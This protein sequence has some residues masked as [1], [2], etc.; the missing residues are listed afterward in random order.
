M[1]D[2]SD[3]LRQI[4]VV[5]GDTVLSCEHHDESKDPVEVKKEADHLEVLRAHL[6]ERPVMGGRGP[7]DWSYLRLFTTVALLHLFVV[8]TVWV[9]PP[10]EA[11]PIDELL[12]TRPVIA[13]VRLI[14]REE[15]PVEVPRPQGG[16]KH[17]FDEGRIGR[18]DRP[19]R[20]A[21]RSKNGAPRVDR[22]QRARDREKALRAGLLGML[23]GRG[24]AAV[25]TVLGPGGLGGGLNEALGGLK[26]SSM[27]GAF[28]AGGLG[29]RGIGPGGG[30]G[31]L[32]I[33]G[34]A[35]HGDGAGPGVTTFGGTKK[36]TRILPGRTIVNGGLKRAE[37]SRV[38]R[39]NLPRFKFCYEK[40]LNANPNLSGKVS[41]YFTIAPT[42]QVA[43][44]TV[45]ESTIGER[46]VERCVL[47]VTRSLR[48]PRP[49]GGGIV[50]VT[51]PFLFA[52]P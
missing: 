23:G 37:I 14:R 19:R 45:R 26:G 41:V 46:R 50:V 35:T 30:G 7:F 11:A 25:G 51:Y 29:T 4:C 43:R 18:R 17:R 39:R 13:G 48:F 10:P 32:S 31:S 52:T 42:G 2:V 5:W 12:R 47:E 16:E 21:H 33:G 38:I 34:L 9:T 8:G 36:P 1:R 40:Q 49:R 28:G 44:A 24:G 15:P 27:G 20:D 3:G 22:D 6:P